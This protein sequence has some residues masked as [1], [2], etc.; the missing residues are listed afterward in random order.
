MHSF[1]KFVD[2]FRRLGLKGNDIGGEGYGHQLMD[3]MAKRQFHLRR[4]NDGSPA[5]RSDIL[6][7]SGE[8]DGQPLVSILSALA[9][10]ATPSWAGGIVHPD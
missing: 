5:K 9:L 7:R 4:F 2:H 8:C 10:A 6:R 3:R 1:G